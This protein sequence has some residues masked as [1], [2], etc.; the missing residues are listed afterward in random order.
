MVPRFVGSNATGPTISWVQPALF[1]SI[2]LVSRRSRDELE[3]PSSRNLSMI[4]YGYEVA[5]STTGL[6]QLH[7]TGIQGNQ[8]FF[9]QKRKIATMDWHFVPCFSDVQTVF[10][11]SRDHVS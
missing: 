5:V 2:L 8:W 11:E 6:T 7:G 10:E 4:T 1:R 3:C 9:G